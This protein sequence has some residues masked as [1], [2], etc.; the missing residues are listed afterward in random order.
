MTPVVQRQAAA[1]LGC[2]E[3]Q[4]EVTAQPHRRYRASGCGQE[5]VYRCAT[6]RLGQTR[7]GVDAGA[8]PR[9]ERAR[10]VQD[11]ASRYLACSGDE[12][13]VTATGETRYSAQGCGRVVHYECASRGNDCCVFATPGAQPVAEAR[14]AEAPQ[15]SASAGSL[16]KAAI[17]AQ[18]ERAMLPRVRACYERALRQPPFAAGV[19]EVKFVIEPTG[20]I[21]RAAVARSSL[22]HQEAESCMIEQVKQVSFPQPD[23]GGIVVV[24]Y[25]FTFTASPPYAECE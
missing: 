11:K 4:V 6:N 23:G 16:S 22:A 9:A 17:K 14:E 21:E 15:S 24:T 13:H 7:C 12:V 5:I 3:A 19:V 2:P 10:R 1:D 25:P 18:I 20:R 8:L